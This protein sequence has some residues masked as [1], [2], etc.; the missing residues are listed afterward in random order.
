MSG[1]RLDYC[2]LSVV[3]ALCSQ[4]AV[5]VCMRVYA[6]ICIAVQKV[7]QCGVS[8]CFVG[9][10]TYKLRSGEGR[11]GSPVICFNDN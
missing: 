5:V 8:G 10:H 4:A 3:N 9:Q 7:T 2:C 6:S 11:D 1:I